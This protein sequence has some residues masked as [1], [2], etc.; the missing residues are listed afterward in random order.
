MIFSS[1]QVSTQ[2]LFYSYISWAPP[3]VKLFMWLLLHMDHGWLLKTADRSEHLHGPQYITQ[4]YG[5]QLSCRLWKCRLIL[6][7]DG[8]IPI[9]I[10][11]PLQEKTGI[12]VQHKLLCWWS[13]YG[14]TLFTRPVRKGVSRWVYILY[15]MECYNMVVMHRALILLKLAGPFTEISL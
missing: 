7:T 8:L 3:K 1:F 5:L 12:Q 11:I 2:Y 10:V 14:C 6:A 13:I 9:K 15:L 4:P